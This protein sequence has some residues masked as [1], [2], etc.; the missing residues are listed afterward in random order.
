[1]GA[2]SWNKNT[3]SSKNQA[4]ERHE[5]ANQSL[6]LTANSSA[7]FENALPR[8]KVGGFSRLSAPQCWRQV[9]FM[10]GLWEN[11]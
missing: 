9:S 2:S 4:V 1:V 7:I 8:I 11:W 6:H 10:F 5:S 3:S